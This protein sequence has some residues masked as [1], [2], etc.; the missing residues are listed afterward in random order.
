M[1]GV[2]EERVELVHFELAPLKYTEAVLERFV[3]VVAEFAHLDADEI[4]LEHSKVEAVWLLC[5]HARLVL[6]RHK[7]NITPLGHV[8]NALAEDRVV[9][10]LVKRGQYNIIFVKG[11]H[12]AVVIDVWLEVWARRKADP[13][14]DL[15]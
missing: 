13:A 3:D 9:H 14:M 11:A 15:D 5:Q 12:R 1:E 7:P 6:R 10:Q 2:F 8:L 4:L